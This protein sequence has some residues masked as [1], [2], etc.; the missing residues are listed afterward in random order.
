MTASWSS[1]GIHLSLGMCA[2]GGAFGNQIVVVLRVT[3]ATHH[4]SSLS[5]PKTITITV[6]APGLVVRLQKQYV[7]V[8]Q[9]KQTSRGKRIDA[10]KQAQIQPK[11][12]AH[13]KQR[14]T[15]FFIVSITKQ[16][17]NAFFS[18]SFLSQSVL[19]PKYTTYSPRIHPS[20][21]SFLNGGSW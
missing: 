21:R 9:R 16:L 13:M 18:S 10:C 12:I 3:V 20:Y 8:S 1:H 11:S 7:S 4:D 14:R 19:L 2:S 6:T 17:K 5:Q 15:R